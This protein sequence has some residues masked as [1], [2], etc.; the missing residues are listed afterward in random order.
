METS[1]PESIEE[2]WRG[3]VNLNRTLIEPTVSLNLSLFFPFFSRQ[4]VELT[5]CSPA[6]LPPPPPG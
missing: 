4:T 3:S 1:L 5:N 2:G 6:H